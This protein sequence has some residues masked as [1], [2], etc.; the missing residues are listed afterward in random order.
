RTRAGHG[1][2]P[3]AARRARMARQHIGDLAM[4]PSTQRAPRVTARAEQAIVRSGILD[5]PYL[6]ALRDETMTL[7]AFRATQE[8]FFFAVTFF[9]RPMAALV[10]RNTNP[11][12]R[13]DILHTLV[14]D[15]GECSEERFHHNAARRF[16]R[17]IGSDPD[18]LDT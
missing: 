9:P 15:H 6:R 16:L 5:N 2:R 11:P 13:L 7:E 18:A 17:L 14:E 1:L 3:R 8:Q 4:P 10:G 12:L